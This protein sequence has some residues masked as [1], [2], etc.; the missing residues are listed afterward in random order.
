MATI[1]NNIKRKIA[2]LIDPSKQ[3]NEAGENVK[4]IL[5]SNWNKGQGGDGI[6]MKPLSK[7]YA[8][9]KKKHGK[10]PIP[11]V[12]LH[13]DLRRAFK[14]KKKTRYNYILTVEGKEKEKLSYYQ[15][16]RDNVIATND[17]MVKELKKE[18]LIG[19]KG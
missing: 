6:K 16:Q 8:E 1:L 4:N 13:G 5:F 2:F 3:L 7:D 9:Y 18:I 17:K 19:L 12:L 14:V 15:E 10:N 11:D